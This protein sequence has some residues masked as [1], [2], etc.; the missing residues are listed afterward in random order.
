MK[1]NYRSLTKQE[2]KEILNKYYQTD[3]GKINKNRFLRLLIYGILCITYSL[4]LIIEQLIKNSS[5]WNYIMALV[6]LIFG[7]VFLIGRHKL[8]IRSINYYLVKNK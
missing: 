4:V 5:L 7:L 1:K 2:R 6:M 8:I 3:M